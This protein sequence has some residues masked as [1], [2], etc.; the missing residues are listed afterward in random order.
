[1]VMSTRTFLVAVGQ[2]EQQ[3]DESACERALSL[4]EQLFE[5]R[6]PKGELFRWLAMNA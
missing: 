5:L 2:S 6:R 3:F 1:M 4:G